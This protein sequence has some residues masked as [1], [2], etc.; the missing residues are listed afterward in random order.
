MFE[1]KERCKVVGWRDPIAKGS[2]D[3][4]PAVRAPR[5]AVADVVGTG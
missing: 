4:A 3:E 2:S 5:L 1:A